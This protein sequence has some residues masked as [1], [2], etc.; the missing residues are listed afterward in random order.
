MKFT[1]YDKESSDPKY[2]ED[3]FRAVNFK[4]DADGNPVCSNGRRFIFK[5]HQHVRGNKY[6]RTEELY[7]C[8]S[9]EG[10][11]LKEKCSR[12]DE[13]RT[14]RIN[15]ELTAIHREVLEN[16][17]SVQG[18]LLRMNR[19]IQ[20]EGTYGSMKW[21]RMYKRAFRRGLKDVILEFTLIA[22]GFNLWKYHNKTQRL[23]E[24]A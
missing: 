24:S 23:E 11:P 15:R 1:M 21:N 20:A 2:R 6:G 19:S 4:Q 22:I 8:E 16:L 9:C 7:E 14:I 12:S 10:C 18:A 17:D 5:R 13:N 3:P